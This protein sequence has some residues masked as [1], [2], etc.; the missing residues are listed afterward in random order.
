MREPKVVSINR[1]V[2]TFGFNRVEFGLL[3]RIQVQQVIE[4]EVVALAQR[5]AGLM[6]LETPMINIYLQNTYGYAFK[7]GH[8]AVCNNAVTIYLPFTQMAAETNMET[9]IVTL[10][11]TVRVSSKAGLDRATICL[12]VE[13]FQEIV[14]QTYT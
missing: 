4:Y 6:D 14:A 3:G 9:N 5:A 12:F 1:Y 7:I 10:R 2:A 8:T 13:K 11:L